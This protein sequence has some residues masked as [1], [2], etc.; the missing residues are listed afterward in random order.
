MI[1]GGRVK[2]LMT[3]MTQ[4]LDHD[5]IWPK[6]PYT[7]PQFR[8]AGHAPNCTGHTPLYVYTHVLQDCTDVRFVSYFNAFIPTFWSGSIRIRQKSLLY[9]QLL[10]IQCAPKTAKLVYNYN[11]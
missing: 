10:D 6:G 2:M 8:L 1:S 3:L 9:V 4:V 5:Q 7:K 11:N